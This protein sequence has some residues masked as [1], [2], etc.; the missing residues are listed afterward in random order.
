MKQDRFMVA[1]GKALGSPSFTR[2]TVQRRIANALRRQV[3]IC[4]DIARDRK[5]ICADAV[6]RVRDGTLYAGIPTAE[7]TENSAR[8]EAQHIEEQIRGLLGDDAVPST[9]A[10]E[11]SI[12]LLAELDELIGQ[13]NSFGGSSQVVPRS[14][15]Q[16]LRNA[17]AGHSVEAA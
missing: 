11:R 9:A 14:L 16:R 3:E 6:A 13:T 8:L 5:E 1:A 7:A 15:L 2:E 4:A 12:L 10:R 17:L